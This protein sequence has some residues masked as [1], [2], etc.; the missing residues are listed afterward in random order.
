MYRFISMI[1]LT[2]L[3][4]L[5]VQAADHSDYVSGSYTDGRS[6]TADC[7]SCHEEQGADFMKTAHWLWKGPAPGIVGLEDGTAVGKE[8]LLNNY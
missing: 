8:N 7:L 5:P 2:I 6:V 4:V 1:F 3:F